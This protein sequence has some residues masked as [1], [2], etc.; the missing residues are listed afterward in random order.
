[1]TS[2]YDPWE[3]LRV[4]PFDSVFSLTDSAINTSILVW[5]ELNDNWDWEVQR[6]LL[7]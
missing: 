3:P 7:L 2:D 5:G 1:M 4:F 6:D